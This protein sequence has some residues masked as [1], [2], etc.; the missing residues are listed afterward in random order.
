MG[1]AYGLRTSPVITGKAMNH[2]IP[3]HF[4][5]QERPDFIVFGFTLTHIAMI[6]SESLRAFGST[7]C[8]ILLSWGA[9]GGGSG[10]GWWLHG[11]KC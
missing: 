8:R 10:C 9:A 11:P 2:R 5:Q 1:W 6:I 7:K 4:P 3:C